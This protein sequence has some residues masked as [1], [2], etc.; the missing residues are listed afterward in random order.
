VQ[1]NGDISNGPSIIGF[2]VIL[3]IGALWASAR[4]PR[5][6]RERYLRNP[7]ELGFVSFWNVLSSRKWTPEGVAYH[8]KQLRIAGIFLL[9]FAFGWLILDLIW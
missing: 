2:I 1:L 5:P 4:N 6:P 3:A 9:A 8:R 7:T